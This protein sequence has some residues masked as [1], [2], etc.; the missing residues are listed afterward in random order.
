MMFK[1]SWE[2]VAYEFQFGVN[3]WIEIQKS[4]FLIM[5]PIPFKRAE[6]QSSEFQMLESVYLKKAT[7]TKSNAML[8][9]LLDA[10]GVAP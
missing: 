2:E 9:V 8:I 7:L 5:V 6:R 1:K 4:F 10:K 3:F